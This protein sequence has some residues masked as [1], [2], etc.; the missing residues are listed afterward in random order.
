MIHEH[1]V[2]TLNQL[3]HKAQDFDGNNLEADDL[4]DFCR[5]GNDYVNIGQ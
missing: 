3:K 4:D 1:G 5:G 2:Q